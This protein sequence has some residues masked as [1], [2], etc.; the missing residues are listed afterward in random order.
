MSSAL[1]LG[2]R[3]VCVFALL[4]L[5]LWVLRRTDGLGARK[6]ATPL[7]V[8]S[9]TRLG[10]SATL[11]VVRVH[12][13]EYVL[14]VT[15]S[16]VTV[17]SSR[18]RADVP[19][20]LPGTVGAALPVTVPAAATSPATTPP[21]AAEFLRGGWQVLRQR[22]VASADVADDELQA[23]IACATASVGAPVSTPVTGA[24]FAADLLAALAAVAPDGEDA[25]HRARAPHPVADGSAA[26]LP[27]RAA[28]RCRTR[29]DALAHEEQQPW[30]PARRP[31]FRPS[32]KGTPG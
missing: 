15:G 11:S 7:Q 2:A 6:R 1:G 10:K 30:S 20:T 9:T 27:R 25:Q 23:A 8:L 16:G 12:D 29:K 18:P 26:A 31:A 14:G 32:E 17:V 24:D 13:E 4:A 19:D 21:S 3:V 5:V 22:P 28:R